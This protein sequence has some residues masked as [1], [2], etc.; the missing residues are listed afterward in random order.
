MEKKICAV[1]LCRVLQRRFNEKFHADWT[2][3]EY[4]MPQG[5]GK[6]FKP[7][8]LIIT[9]LPVLSQSIID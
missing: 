2:I 8:I 6:C 4:L 3:Q 7:F 9:V 5:L 1:D